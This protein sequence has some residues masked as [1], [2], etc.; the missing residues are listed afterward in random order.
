MS[1]WPSIGCPSGLIT[2][3]KNPSPTG[4]ERT[5]PVRL[6]CCP[7]ASFSESP[8][9]T[10]P[11]LCS[12]RLSATPNTPPVNSR[13]SWVITDGKPSTCAMPSPVSITVPT[14]SLAVSEVKELTYSSIAPWM[15]SAE[16]VNSAM[17]FRLPACRWSG[18][19]GVSVR[20]LTLSSGETRR[21]RTVDDLVADCDREPAEQLGVD[22]NLRGNR[23]TVD[24]AEHFGEAGLLG[25]T[26]L[27]RRSDACNDFAA[28]SHRYFSQAL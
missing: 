20:Q 14:S 8:R 4:T 12:S 23:M 5:S 26:Q 10:V 3:P 18:V 27:G 9:I 17:G 7:C 15:S 24:P 25:V 19:G 6:T 2:R 28:P 11:M 13:S 21:K 22:L 16:I 1:P